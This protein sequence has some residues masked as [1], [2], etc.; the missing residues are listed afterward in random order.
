ML[1]VAMTAGLRPGELYGLAIGHFDIDNAGIGWV[2]IRRQV[3][4]INGRASLV[5]RL[6][7]EP[8]SRTARRTIPVYGEIVLAV[9]LT[10]TNSTLGPV[11]CSLPTLPGGTSLQTT[12]AA[13][14]T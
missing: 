9:R 3:V 12:S 11:A 2:S 1:A 10:P 8:G 6:K 13:A 5:S 14:D 4:T 7:G